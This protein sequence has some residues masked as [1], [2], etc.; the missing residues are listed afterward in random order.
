MLTYQDLLSVGIEDKNSDKLTAWVLAAIGTYEHSDE[1]MTAVTAEKYYDGENPTINEYERVIYDL[2]GK[3]QV[4]M[5]TAN[6]KIASQFFG[7]VVDQQVSYLLANGVT[8]QNDDTEDRLGPDWQRA[9][10]RAAR[11]ALIGGVSFGLWD[12][13]KLTPYKR[14]NFVPLLDEYSGDLSAGIWFH[15]MDTTK[16]LSARLYLP[17]GYIEY[18]QQDNKPLAVY[19]PFRGYQHIVRTSDGNAP[20][21]EDRNPYGALPIV[22][23]A[24]GE[25]WRSELSGKRNTLD[26][27]DLARSKMV[28][29][30][31]EGALIYWVLRNYGGMEDMDLMEFRRRIEMLHAV[32]INADAGSDATPHTIEAPFEGTKITI[33]ELRSALYEDFNAFDSDS[34]TASNQSATAIQAAYTRLDLKTDDFETE[35]VTPFIEGV[36]RLAG[37]DDKPSYTR[38]RQINKMEETQTIVVQASYLGREYT[39]KK[40]LTINGDIDQYDEVARQVDAENAERLSFGDVT[41]DA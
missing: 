12:G 20:E 29:N 1:Y 40:L 7:N 23:F 4:D 5:W 36:L 15:R 2:Q 8:F 30:T 25:K 32:K 11:Y 22:P 9:L 17:D 18:R 31:D 33:D 28:N 21:I 26:A 6:H 14:Q 39:M 13:T 27:L 41:D 19:A 35:G 16:P 10:T 34:V 37:I 3:A 38:N 24:N